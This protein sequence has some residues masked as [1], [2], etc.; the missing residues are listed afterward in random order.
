MKLADPASAV[1]F[2]CTFILFFG[3][4]G[5]YLAKIVKQPGV[6]GE[7]LMGV[8]VG[9]I[10]YFAGLQLMYILRDAP[11]VFSIVQSMLTGTP[12]ASAVSSVIT[13][14]L[15]ASKVWT[16]LSGPQG[17]DWIK[18]AFVMDALARYGVIF[19]LFMVG[20]ESSISELKKTGR[21]SVQVAI[22]GVIA[23]VAL[24]LLALY[25]LMPNA[26]FSTSLFVAATLSA[27]SVGIT[28][29]VLKDMHKLQTRESKT[30]LGAAML[31]DVLGLILLAI[32]SGLVINDGFHL[33]P[34]VKIILSAVLF[35]PVA[36]LVGPWVLRYMIS[37]VQFLEPWE[38]KLLVSFIFV[39]CLSWL[40]T[41][42]Q[43]SSI[44]GA[45]VAGIILHDGLFE[46]RDRKL[47]NPQLIKHLMA[48]L[49]AIFAPLFFMLIGIQVRVETFLDWH[50][51]IFALGLI[52][53]A[54]VGKLLSGLG[55]S[56]RDDRLLIGIGMMPRGEVGL[57]FAS[58][59][60]SIG[61]IPDALFSGIILMVVVT[62]VLTPLWMKVRYKKVSVA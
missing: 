5:R 11:A 60:K 25:A 51:L 38:G 31:D 40:A 9:N 62:T 6:L 43:M 8:L 47:S 28:A 33:L 23:P 32:V 3:I 15:Y 37:C 36:L 22:I 14:P 24:G 41:I 27:T 61:V 59:G 34:V 30:I 7:L 44:I 18:V 45:F 58:V 55:G 35:F 20:L 56:R 39:M 49:E 48:P 16:A 1:I 17:N 4:V 42:V 46:T 29:R 12:I 50:V 13:E 19:L 10:G 57:I 52:V 2:W 26:T 53:V 54:I 21:E